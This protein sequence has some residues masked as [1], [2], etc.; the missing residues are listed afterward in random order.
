MLTLNDPLRISSI[1][2]NAHGGA[3]G[4]TI[5]PGKRGPSAFGGRHERDLDS[6]IDVVEAW[7]AH[8]VLTLVEDHELRTFGIEGLGRAV[9]DRFMEWHHHPIVDVNVPGA[10][11]ERSWPA[12]STALRAL[13]A[14]GGK[15]L[16]H[17]RGGLGRAGMVAARLLV[18]DGMAPDRAIA[19]VRS[20]RGAGAIE[21]RAQEAWVESG[22]AQ[23]VARSEI[24][25]RDRA[26]GAV[27]GLAVGDAVGTTLEFMPKPPR[28]CIYG[29]IGGGPFRLRAGQW[30]DDTAMAM[31]LADSLEADP[32]L[33][34]RD[35]MDRFVDWHQNGTYSC[36]GKCFDIGNA[37]VAALRRYQ[38][39]GDPIAGSTD[40]YSAGNGSIMRLSPVAVRHSNDRGELLRVADLQGM[41][42]HAAPEARASVATLAEILAEA[43]SGR[44]LTDLATGPLSLGVKGYAPG[45][46]R[47]A[48]KGSG[49][50]VASL[51]AALWAVS[52]TTSFETAILAA[53]NLGEDADT[54]AA[55]AGQI[56][57][58]VYGL[59]GIPDDWLEHLAWRE[60]IEATAGRL[61]DASGLAAAA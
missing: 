46:P 55:I 32:A 15:V 4:V 5:A 11:F 2:A 9:I 60:R 39:D 34:P 23:A 33:D 25:I 38:A 59:S 42:T 45:Q 57:G 7:G 50:V 1:P 8:A 28:A 56:A 16:I 14:R 44:S 40:P 24:T 31:A 19:T 41:T 58:A 35:L 36:T 52:T 26:L 6:D 17:C 49:Y 37:T 53:A 20:A 51:H 47:E 18:E 10:E 30:T 3:W 27:V 29:M 61:F 13:V 48:I 22:R 54:T 12:L 21:T 43:I